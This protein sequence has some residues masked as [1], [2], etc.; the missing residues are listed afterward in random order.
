MV[1]T[2]PSMAEAHLF[3]FH[4]GTDWTVHDP[5][6]NEG[7]TGRS[8][9]P[10]THT[11]LSLKLTGYPHASQRG[12]GVTPRKLAEAGRGTR[13]PES[14]SLRPPP[15]LRAAHCPERRAWQGPGRSAR[16]VETRRQGLEMLSAFPWERLLRETQLP[17]KQRPE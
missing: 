14:R 7:C 12:G 3:P 9:V 1:E 13:G 5:F 11:V 2:K 17:A 15:R 10:H 16:D 8:G 4:L 6:I